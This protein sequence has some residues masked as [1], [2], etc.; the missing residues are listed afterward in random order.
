MEQ[1]N[2]SKLQVAVYI[3]NIPKYIFPE[4]DS[5]INEE[6][7]FTITTEMNHRKKSNNK[8]KDER[9]WQFRK[10]NNMAAKKSRNTHK[11]KVDQTAK[12]ADLLQKKNKSLSEEITMIRE[13]S[14]MLRKLLEEYEPGY[15][16]KDTDACNKNHCLLHKPYS[17]R[18]TLI[19]DFIH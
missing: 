4:N 1:I 8:V 7:H 2:S 9:Y 11:M 14:L 13:E 6:M 12:Y 16:S 17:N 10:Q 5:V 15:L 18:D 3:E 19:Q